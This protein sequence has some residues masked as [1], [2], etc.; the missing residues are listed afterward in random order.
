MVCVV[1]RKFVLIS[2]CSRSCLESQTICRAI[3]RL[4]L[5]PVS[6]P[7]WSRPRWM[8]WR[9]ATWT[10]LLVNTKAHSIVPGLWW[11][12][13]VPQPFIKGE[14]SNSTTVTVILVLHV[15]LYTKHYILGPWFSVEKMEGKWETWLCEIKAYV[16]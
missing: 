3:L 4:R 14:R 1:F 7:Q 10:L 5:E 16:E 15:K 12:R 8:S 11:P 9:L 6:S 13:K 2:F